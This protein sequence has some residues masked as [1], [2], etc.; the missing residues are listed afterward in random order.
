MKEHQQDIFDD[1]QLAELLKQE[2]Y[3]TTD[4]PWFTRRVLNRLPARRRNGWFMTAI[5]VMVAMVCVITW[6]SVI[7]GMDGAVTVRDFVY[8]AIMVAVTLYAVVSAVVT[9]VRAD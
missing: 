6:H 7:T 9:V 2:A 5:Y 8:L 3:Q 4:N 1:N